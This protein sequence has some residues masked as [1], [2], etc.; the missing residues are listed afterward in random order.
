[1]SQANVEIVR[2]IYAAW[3]EGRS[4]SD[5]IDADIE[6]VNPH[7]AVEPGI[8]RGRASFARIRDAY[9]DVKVAP[10]RFLDAGDHVVVLAEITG[11]SRGAG[12]PVRLKQ[13]Y[14]WTIHDGRAV[15]FHWFNSENEALEAV[16]L[17]E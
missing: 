9:D 14:V 17:L 1:M 5:F 7:Y 4:A 11:K 16:G 10:R 2:S 6:Y 8:I 15:R 13:G 3:N 12:V